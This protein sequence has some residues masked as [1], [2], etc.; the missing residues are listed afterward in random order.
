MDAVLPPSAFIRVHLRFV[1]LPGLFEN[2]L[3][4]KLAFGQS[5]NSGAAKKYFADF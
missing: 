5:V 3:F 1:L 4:Q 2:H